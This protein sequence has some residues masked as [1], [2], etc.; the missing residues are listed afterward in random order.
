MARL[1]LEKRFE[2]TTEQTHGQDVVRHASHIDLTSELMPKREDERLNCK[3]A[4]DMLNTRLCDRRYYGCRFTSSLSEQ[5]ECNLTRCDGNDMH[6]F[7]REVIERPT[8]DEYNIKQGIC[9]KTRLSPMR[10]HA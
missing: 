6:R 1:M 8:R 4:S 10:Q 9:P 2:N 3:H 5:I 7:V